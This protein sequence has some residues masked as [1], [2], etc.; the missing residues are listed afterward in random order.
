M[1]I[2]LPFTSEDEGTFDCFVEEPGQD[3]V[4]GSRNEEDHLTGIKMGDLACGLIRLAA[5]DSIW[6]MFWMRRSGRSLVMTFENLIGAK[7][8][9]S[10]GSLRDMKLQDKTLEHMILLGGRWPSTGLRKILWQI[11]SFLGLSKARS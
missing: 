1:D 6:R 9:S 11:C 7:R 10:S 8:L 2:S 3:T 4:F 5:L